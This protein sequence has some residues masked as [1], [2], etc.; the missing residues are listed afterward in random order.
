VVHGRIAP[1]HVSGHANAEELKLMLNL[2]EPEAFIPVHGEYRQL[3]HHAA[4]AVDC[5]VPDENVLVVEDGA[6]VEL[7]DQAIRVAAERVSHGY[8]YVDGLGVGDVGTEVLRDRRA[9]GDD[10]V[11]TCVVTID[12]QTG[13]IISG[14]DLVTR[15]F[16]YEPEAEA[17]LAKAREEVV[18]SLRTAAEDG[19]LDIASLQRHIRQAL[20]H[21]LWAEI[22]RRPVI[23]PVVMEV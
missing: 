14:P 7:T 8:L 17:L 12:G 2:V 11:I 15:G 10:G 22:R 21:F 19:A 3:R 20:R 4:L 18:A 9:L 16:T 23:L 5:G 1:V 6:I 13:Q